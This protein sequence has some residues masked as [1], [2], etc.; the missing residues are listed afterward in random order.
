MRSRWSVSLVVAF[1]VSSPGAASGAEGVLEINQT[2]MDRTGCFAGD[3][4][5]PGVR[6]DGSAGR[7]YRLT[8]D[9][10]VN[11]NTTAIVVA[12]DDVTIDLNGFTIH[13]IN[14]C[15]AGAVRGASC[16]A[17]GIG[18]G[19]AVDS[20]SRRG[21]VVRDGAVIGMG[22]DGIRLGAHA[23]VHGLEPQVGGDVGR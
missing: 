12:A 23:R 17:S 13:S 8:S 5:G 6:I 14:S 16:S 15:T 22:S 2:C 20:T 9:L 11:L 3:A 1:I 19:I 21:T 18:A 4:P 7:S 10:S